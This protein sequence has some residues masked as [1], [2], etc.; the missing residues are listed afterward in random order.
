MVLN[1][2]YNLWDMVYLITDPDQ[3]QRMVTCI[4]IQATGL[5]YELS[6]GSTGS[7]HYEKEISETKNILANVS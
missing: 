5:V 6:F 2:K 3:H 1:N 7:D 4:K